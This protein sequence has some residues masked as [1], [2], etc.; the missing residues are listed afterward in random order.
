[1]SQ[2][3]L[4]SHDYTDRINRKNKS[5]LSGTESLPAFEYD[6]KQLSQQNE[7]QSVNNLTI[8]VNKK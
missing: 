1:M 3:K 7:L 4:S 8:S 5:K 6:I 2:K